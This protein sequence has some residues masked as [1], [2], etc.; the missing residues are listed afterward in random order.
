M[1]GENRDLLGDSP[2]H[3]GELL[4][5]PRVTLAL[6]AIFLILLP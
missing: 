6:Y 4:I 1:L 3:K 5:E 2:L